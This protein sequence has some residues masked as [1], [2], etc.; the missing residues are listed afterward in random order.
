MKKNVRLMSLILAL[1]LMISVFAGTAAFAADTEPT[2]ITFPHAFDTIDE[3]GVESMWDIA[4]AVNKPDQEITAKSSDAS[5]ISLEFDKKVTNV[6]PPYSSFMMKAYKKGKVTLTFTTTDG[7]SVSRT[8]TVGDSNHVSY[9]LSSDTTQNFSI[10]SGNSYFIKIHATDVSGLMTVIPKLTSSDPKGLRTTLVDFNDAK[11]D[12]V[13]RVDA[14]G[15]VGQAYNLYLGIANVIPKKLC[16]VTITAHKNLKLDTTGAVVYACNIGDTYR[17]TAYTSSSAVPAASTNNALTSVRYLRKVTGGYEYEMKALKSGQSI[18][19]VSQNG[20]TA[21]FPVSVNYLNASG[22]D[23]YDN[24][25]SIVS[26]SPGKMTYA[27][28][29][30]YTYRFAIMGGGEPRFA[31]GTAGVLSTQLVKKDGINYYVKATA[32]GKVKD[33]TTLYVS[34]PNAQ[35]N[36]KDYKV[37][38]CDAILTQMKSD[39][40]GNFSVKQGMSYTFKITGATSFHADADGVFKTE[41]V[42]TVGT[43]MYYK[44]TAIGEPGKLADFYMAANGQPEQKVCTVTVG[45]P[46]APIVIQSDTNTDFS[47]V[48]KASYQFKITVPGVPVVNFNTGTAGV[49]EIALVRHTGDDFFYKITAVGQSGK[50]AGIYASVPGQTAKKICKVSIA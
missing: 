1:T 27:V 6:T 34:F 42:K 28:G 50:E 30:S 3:I 32:I 22:L 10:P 2:T 20:E 24:A 19:R 46:P 35:R 13:F 21:S 4:V 18:I 16:A 38:V 33:G 43:A 9:I 8:V 40:T 12:I 45:P 47:I 29:E 26:D 39:T 48:P 15:S 7:T 5:I 49:F 14:A 11:H 37:A 44:I 25:P 23:G 17:F 31:A 36:Y 41:L